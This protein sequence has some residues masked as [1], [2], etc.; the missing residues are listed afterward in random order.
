M[1][2]STLNGDTNQ[3]KSSSAPRFLDVSWLSAFPEEKERLFYGQN[4]VFEIAD[5]YEASTGKTY[6]ETLRRFNLFQKMVKNSDVDWLKVG[7]NSPMITKLIKLICLQI[8]KRED[9]I[10]EKKSDYND[11][12]DEKKKSDD[13]DMDDDDKSSDS[14]DDDDIGMEYDERLFD[15]FCKNE[16]NDWIAIRSYTSIP[17]PL[18][19][20]FIT[21]KG[22]IICFDKICKLFPFIKKLVLNELNINFMDQEIKNYEHSMS[23]FIKFLKINK[24]KYKRK[25]CNLRE[26]ILESKHERNGKINSTLQKRANKIQKRYKKKGWKHIQV[27]YDFNLER[28]HQLKLK[29]GKL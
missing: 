10:E 15:H 13:E 29:I 20:S 18:R 5:I 25:I 14:D 16:H 26:I 4:V 22:K 1:V 21:K 27:C 19:Q 3:I 28:S 6:G 12:N 17:L 9:I 11:D 23:E 7:E 24:Q 2:E 8:T